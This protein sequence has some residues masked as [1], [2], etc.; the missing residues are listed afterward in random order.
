MPQP[1]QL[2]R[3]DIRGMTVDQIAQ[4]HTEGRLAV[5]LGGDPPHN[6]DKPTRADLKRMSA[7]AIATAQ[8]EG[9]LDHLLAGDQT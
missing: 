2:T 6:P 4:A 1:E 7:E 8:R 5:L 9:R 3:E